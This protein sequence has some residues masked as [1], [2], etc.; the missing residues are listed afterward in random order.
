MNTE[1]WK[2]IEGYEGYYQVSNLGNVR[3]LDRIEYDPF[4]RGGCNGR[5]RLLKGRVLKQG[6]GTNGYRYV[7][8]SVNQKS[9]K[10]S[11]HRLVAE[12]FIPNP[13]NLPTVDH[14]NRN[15]TDNTVS[16]LRWLSHYDNCATI[17]I[18]QHYYD[19]SLERNPTAKTVVGIKDG[20][21]VETFDCAKKMTDKYSIKYSTLKQQLQKNKCY[22]NGINFHY[23]T[24]TNKK[25]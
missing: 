19:K 2:D 3:S 24:Y 23:E 7:N 17:H 9:K 8:L 6:T 13:D 15:K 12:A 18:G 1:I 16:N 11:I 20:E 14:I 25:I 10:Y 5:K 4:N 22:I 21:I